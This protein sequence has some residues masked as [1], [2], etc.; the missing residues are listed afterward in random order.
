MSCQEQEIRAFLSDYVLELLPAAQVQ[1]VE[2][3]LAECEH[4]WSIVRQDR[5]LG[6]AVSVTVRAA[7]QPVLPRIPSLMPVPAPRRS[8]QLY[9]WQPLAA[10]ALLA[11]LYLGSLQMIQPRGPYA[12]PTLPTTTLV[13]TATHMPTAGSTETPSGTAPL[14][15]P[16][17][18]ESPVISPPS[19]PARPARLP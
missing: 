1:L 8:R 7:A 14:S 9:L 19:S 3:H 18:V 12:P 10:L 17:V 16:L 2:A 6:R 13:A 15:S 11:M 4:C 5:E